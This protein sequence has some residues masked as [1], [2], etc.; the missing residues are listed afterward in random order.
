L[1]PAILSEVRSQ[2]VAG[3]STTAEIGRN[4]RDTL[5]PLLLADADGFDKGKISRIGRL[6]Q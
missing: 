5:I 4:V 6:Q 3:E 1:V 2:L